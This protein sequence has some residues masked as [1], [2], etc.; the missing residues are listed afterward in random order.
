MSGKTSNFPLGY[1]G[2]VSGEYLDILNYLH[3]VA[4]NVPTISLRYRPF[5]ARRSLLASL[6]YTWILLL[7]VTLAETSNLNERIC[8]KVMLSMRPGY[9]TIRNHFGSKQPVVR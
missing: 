9:V 3:K 6:D 4:A 7:G 8:V 2:F 5:R 1:N